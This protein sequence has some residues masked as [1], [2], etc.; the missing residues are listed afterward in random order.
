MPTLSDWSVKQQ[1]AAALNNCRVGAPRVLVE[2]STQHPLLDG[3]EP[4]AEFALRLQRAIELVRQLEGQGYAV[5]VLVAASRHREGDVADV[6]SLGQAGETW[7]LAHGLPRAQ[8][9]DGEAL[10]KRFKGPDHRWPGVYH[11]AD[12]AYIAATLFQAES[13]YAAL[14]CV[15]GQAQLHRKLLHYLWLGC[16][17]IMHAVWVPGAFHDPVLEVQKLVFVRDEDPD[18]QGEDSVPAR[19]A[20]ASRQ[21]HEEATQ[22]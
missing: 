14:H 10:I 16:E 6:V 12:E 7:L 9:L 17:P 11:S 21:V 22:P 8:V 3:R 15:A 2:V 20:R 5:D 4:G 1:Q 19:R 13:H 18:W